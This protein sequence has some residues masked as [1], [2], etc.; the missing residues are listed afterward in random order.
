[1]IGAS[2]RRGGTH[3]SVRLGSARFGSARCSAA[4]C[5]VGG[6]MTRY[7]RSNHGRKPKKIHRYMSFGRAFIDGSFEFV[8][9]DAEPS[10]N[11]C[12]P[13]GRIDERIT[14]RLIQCFSAINRS[15]AACITRDA[16]LFR[17]TVTGRPPFEAESSEERYSNEEKIKISRPRYENSLTRSLWQLI[18]IKSQTIERHV[19]SALMQRSRA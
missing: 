6:T 11:S 7:T 1:M 16:F 8:E 13:A 19:C 17:R 2:D 3:G 10:Q 9:Y 18:A 15:P 14:V 4:R 12:I 5:G